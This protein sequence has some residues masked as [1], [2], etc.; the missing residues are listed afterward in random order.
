MVFL[1]A[2]LLRQWFYHFKMQSKMLSQL[3]NSARSCDVFIP[4]FK[5]VFFPVGDYF[6]LITMKKIRSSP[7]GVFLGKGVL[8]KYRKFRGEH[9]CLSVISIKLQNNF[10]KI[11]LRHGCSPVNLLHIFRT[12]FPK[13]TPGWLFLKKFTGNIWQQITYIP[14]SQNESG[15]QNSYCR[16]HKIVM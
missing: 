1:F 10:I 12:P 6:I 9:P 7:P 15:N 5:H 2:S 11:T 3:L 8:K 16:H 4:K 14:L 13:N